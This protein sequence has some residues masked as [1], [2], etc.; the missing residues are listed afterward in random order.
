MWLKQ[1]CT[2]DSV[3]DTDLTLI[4]FSSLLADVQMNRFMYFLP[5]SISK[6]SSLTNE[7]KRDDTDPSKRRKEKPKM[8]KNMDMVGDWN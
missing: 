8:N 3:L 5:P 4:E 6:V 2:K 7:K 1:C